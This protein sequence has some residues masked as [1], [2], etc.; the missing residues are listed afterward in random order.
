MDKVSVIIT[1]AFEPKTIGQAI[2]AILTQD[3]PALLEIL[4]V[5]P[6]KKTAQV[7]NSY[8][9][10]NK[11]VRLLKDKGKG[12]PEALNLAFKKVKGDLLVLTD[13]DVQITE[14]SLLNLLK[15]FSNPA[16][17]GVSGHPLPT[18]SKNNLLGFWS[19]FLT[20][21]AHRIRLERNRKGQFIELSGY[22]LAIRRKLV[23]PIP[24]QTLA[25]DSLLSHQVAR[26]NLLTK[27]SPEAKVLV[28]YPTSIPDW[29][30]QKRRSA[31]EYWKSHYSSGQKMR[32][33]LK[34][35]LLGLR[36]ALNY[37]ENFKEFFWLILL[38]GARI[39]LWS[40]II[41]LSLSFGSSKKLWVRVKSTK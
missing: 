13:G 34:E 31:F 28:K 17:G 32:S 7:A 26:A 38:F 21:S 11:K 9:S 41:V 36:Y 16:V 22:L 1:S 33:P 40:Q 18:N 6:D 15:P 12:K 35:A 37:P 24:S 14:G 25:D 19:H 23:A 27:Y 10:K 8:S 5:S 4:V 30:K 39:I 29:F 3:F 20:E 2:E